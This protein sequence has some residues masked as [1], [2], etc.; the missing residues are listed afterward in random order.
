VI[1]TLA[2]LQDS[3]T[4]TNINLYCYKLHL[5]VYHLSWG[6][7]SRCSRFHWCEGCNGGCGCY[8]AWTN[9]FLNDDHSWG[10]GSCSHCGRGP[11]A[12]VPQSSSCVTGESS[13]QWMSSWLLASTVLRR[14]LRSRICCRS[15]WRNSRIASLSCST[16]EQVPGGMDVV[17]AKRTCDW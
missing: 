8:A 15:S 7:C 3:F 17:V 1:V 9:L 11:H 6:S 10:G 4:M 2:P 16:A 13:Y 12:K 14:L 5:H